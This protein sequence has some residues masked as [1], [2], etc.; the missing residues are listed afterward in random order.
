LI[1][2]QIILFLRSIYENLKVFRQSAV[3]QHNI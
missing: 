3:T 1:I 2:A